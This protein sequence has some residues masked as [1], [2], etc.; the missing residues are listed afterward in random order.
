MIFKGEALQVDR[1]PGGGARLDFNLRGSPVNKFNRSTLEELRAA[2]DELAQSRIAGLVFTSSKP[3]FIVGA[4]IAEF[5]AMFSEAGEQ[6]RA[7]L[8]E[9]CEIF[10][11]VED[12]PF[13]TVAALDGVALGGGFELAVAADFRIGTERAVVGFPEVKLGILPGFGGTVRLPRLIGADNANQWIS[14][15]DQIQAD[16]AFREGALDAVVPRDLLVSGAEKIIRQ[17]NAGKLDYR[18]VR[19]RKTSPLKLSPLE[20]QVAFD[21]AGAMV[22]AKA[23]PHYPA[24]VAAVRSMRESAG[25]DRAEALRKEHETFLQLAG[26]AVCFNLVQIF[27]NERLL[28]GN[29]RK[30]LPAAAEVKSAAVLGAGIMGGGIAFQSA[31]RGVP[32]VM[33]DIARESLDLGMREVSEQLDKRRARGRIDAR[34]MTEVLSRI[35]PTLEYGRLGRADIVVEAVVENSAVKQQVLGELERQ[36]PESA[37]I[38][39]NTSTISIDELAGALRRPENFCG[40]H[41]FNPVPVMPLVE[42]VRGESSS[43]RAVATAAAYAKALGKKPIVVNNCPGFLVNRILFPY[44]GAFSALIRDGADFRQIDKVM[45]D[46][47]WPMGPASL[48]DVIGIDTAAHCQHV[49]GSAFARMAHTFESAVDLLYGKGDFGRKTGAGFYSYETDRRGKP[50]KSPREQSVRWIARAQKTDGKPD[51]QEIRD[52][53]MIAMC[54]EAARCLEDGIVASPVEVDMGLILGLGFPAFRG[55]ALRFI[56]NMGLARF[57]ALADRYRGLGSLYYPTGKMRAMAAGGETFYRQA[58]EV[59]P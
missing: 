13:P 16:Q 5:P 47:G 26:G 22:A 48:L 29:I 15:G 14:S 2:I 53:M 41:F 45:E 51:D 52:R 28:S 36:I 59:G 23:G 20:L 12:L 30:M 18:S 7:W 31:L 9:G 46:F 25:L 11:A 44:F 33:K 50:V 17:A 24:P 56:D 3:A 10:N 1:L 43:E 32:V 57:C 38:A 8:E 34:Q 6:L 21:T 58:G 55:G 39:S 35:E 42:V 54:L 4:D 37:I 49:L 40:M 27:L 19:R